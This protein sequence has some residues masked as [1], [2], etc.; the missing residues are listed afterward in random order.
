MLVT[1]APC[2]PVTSEAWGV[3]SSGMMDV[4]GDHG[5]RSTVRLCRGQPT[6]EPA[7]GIAGFY[8]SCP[9]SSSF[10]WAHRDSRMGLPRAKAAIRGQRRARAFLLG[11]A[12]QNKDAG[13]RMHTYE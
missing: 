5:A 11:P 6:Q 7:R 1:V 2:E 12:T 3:T 4:M 9:R 10:W 13:M 8:T